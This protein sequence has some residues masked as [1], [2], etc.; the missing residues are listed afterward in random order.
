MDHYAAQRQVDDQGKE[1]GLQNRAHAQVGLMNNDIVPIRRTNLNIFR[2]CIVVDSN[3]IFLPSKIQMRTKC[4]YNV[5]L[6]F[7]APGPDK[8]GCL[9]S[10]N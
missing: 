7:T 1:Q 5:F 4:T 2:N 9:A 6:C 3:D 8:F 10:K